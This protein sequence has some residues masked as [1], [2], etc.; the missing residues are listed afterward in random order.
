MKPTSSN[1]EAGFLPVAQFRALLTQ[2]IGAP[3]VPQAPTATKAFAPATKHI[4]TAKP[5]L[6]R[7]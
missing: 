7:R 1:S 4:A 2:L 6:R 5:K 3:V